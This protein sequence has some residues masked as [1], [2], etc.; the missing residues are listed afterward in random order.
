VNRIQSLLVVSAF[1]FD[2]VPFPLSLILNILARGE[3]YSIHAPYR[4]TVSICF[5]VQYVMVTTI[6]IVIQSVSRRQ[7]NGEG[8]LAP[9]RN[10]VVPAT[11][12]RAKRVAAR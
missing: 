4:Y 7:T 2:G 11:S 9:E 1:D 10:C 5:N 3:V 6:S 8:P 12:N